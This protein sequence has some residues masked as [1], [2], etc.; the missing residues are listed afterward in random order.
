[1]DSESL[2]VAAAALSGLAAMPVA[3]AGLYLLLVVRPTTFSFN[4]LYL[5]G[6]AITIGTGPAYAIGLVAAAAVG[7]GFGIVVG[8]L[9][10][11]LEIDSV[12]WAWGALI[13]TALSVVTGTTLGQLRLVHKSIRNG[14]LGEPGLFA[15]NHGRATVVALIAAHTG[16]GAV[17]SA[18]Y[19]GLA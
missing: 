2:D 14:Q 5:A 15:I 16:F 7:A 17:A 4:P 11:G 3:L 18:L 6:A 9:L 19:E 8:G 13:G 1:M 12:S 10:N